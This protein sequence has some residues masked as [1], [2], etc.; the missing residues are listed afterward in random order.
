MP[1]NPPV[2]AI[3]FWGLV[4]FSLLVV[5]HEGGHFFA[6]RFFGVRVHEF[7]L[8][9]PGPSLKWRS[10]KTGTAY[11]VTAI[12]L[13][14]YVRIAGME[15]GAEDELL[16]PALKTVAVAGSLD[17]ADLAETLHV[18]HDR[19][20]ALLNTLDDWNSIEHDPGSEGSYRTLVQADAGTD[21]AQLIDRERTS[22]YRGLKTWQRIT[23]LAMGVL[24]NLVTAIVIFTVTL[25]AF[26]YQQPSLKLDTVEP[27]TP[28]LLAGLRAGDRLTSFDGQKVAD[29]QSM[30]VH[31]EK[32]RPGQTV[33]IGYIRNGTPGVARATLAEHN[34]KPYLGVKAS[35]ENVR[36]SVWAAL[37]QSFV[38]TGLVFVAIAQFFN[39]ATFQQSL[40]G[41]RSVVGISVETA[42]AA[43]AG[44]LPYA[45]IVALLSLSLGVMNILPIPPLDGGKIAVE[46]VERLIHRPLPR[47]VSLGLSLAGAVLLFSLIGYLMYADVVRIVT[48]G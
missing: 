20:M 48:G 28:A 8:G 44:A 47:A 24:M 4:T 12:P 18:P 41:A 9:L 35:I 33:T 2:I 26:G 40:Q 19:A 1:G 5:I 14:G 31:I 23:V 10:K 36:L 32:S 27:A 39:P 11:G 37:G 30:L 46:I 45:W 17:A 42:R 21:P 15:P 13:G 22:T 25:S 6:A 7:M 3:V 34:G 29:W 38:W 43:S 16:G